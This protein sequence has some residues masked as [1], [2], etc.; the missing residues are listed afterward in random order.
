MTRP[1]ASVGS[2][3]RCSSFAAGICHLSGY[4]PNRDKRDPKKCL[5]GGKATW[6]GLE[7]R[8]RGR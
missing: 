4:C 3:G 6:C 7:M 1:D 2:T 5:S 8:G